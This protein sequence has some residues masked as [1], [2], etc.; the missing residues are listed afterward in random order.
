MSWIKIDQ[1]VQVEVL[2]LF[3]ILKSLKAS[4]L[5]YSAKLKAKKYFSQQCY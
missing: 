3:K 4:V 1:S 2:F 5:Y